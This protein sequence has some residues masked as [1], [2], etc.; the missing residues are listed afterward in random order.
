MKSNRRGF[1]QQAALASAALA[2][3]VLPGCSAKE[4]PNVLWLIS[5]DTSPDWSCYGNQVVR[6]PNIDRLA[7]QGV[8]FDNAFA[9]CPVCSPSRSGFM[10]GMYQTSIGAHQHRTRFRTP[11]PD[12]VRVIT[13]YFRQAGYFT[14]NG[15]GTDNTKAGKT[16]WNFEVEGEAFDGTD[17]SQREP[18]QPFFAQYNFSLT[19]RTFQRNPDH[20]IDPSDVEIP[21]YYPDH[22]ITRRDWADYLESLQVLDG[23]LGAVLQRLEDEGLADNTIVVYFGDHGRPHVRGK[24]WLYEGGIRVPLIIRWP[25]HLPAGKVS[26]DL[27][28]LID[29]APTCLSL[30]GEEPPEHLQGQN[31]FDKDISQ[32]EA[33]FSAR[34]RCDGTVDRIRCVRTKQYKYIRNYYPERPYTQF[35]GYKK[36][37]YPV[38]TLMQLLARKGELTDE[39]MNF[40]AATRPPEELYDLN[41][42]PYELYNLADNNEYS[43][44]LAELRDELD[45]W[46]EDTGD[47][48]EQPENPEEQQY[49]IDMMAERHIER[50]TQRGISPE[51]SD[52][53][54]LVYW[55]NQLLK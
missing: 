36:Q 4:R 5:E 12:P 45:Q 13:E 23:Q 20:P 52:E 1:L 44:I 9:T 39:Q 25:G 7:S 6:T 26:D 30:I 11:L 2:L 14:S 51:I 54:Y 40:M 46:I 38:L 24:Q 31:I 27:V 33:V 49:S 28:S 16:D 8:R 42:D 10:T 18:G 3:P 15:K 19:H 55:E 48:G 53:E 37:Q 43:E 35:N 22:P 21:P 47:M 34:D 29:L 41:K 17:W 50:M 32:R